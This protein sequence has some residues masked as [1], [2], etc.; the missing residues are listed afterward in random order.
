MNIFVVDEDPQI[1]ARML[2]DKH[3]I[4]MILESAQM[5]STVM[6][7]NNVANPPYRSTHKHHPCTKWAGETMDN[8][9]WLIRHFG[10]MCH[11]YT[12]RY[13]KVHKCQ[14]YFQDF[15][16]AGYHVTPGPLT[17]FAL[18]MPEQYRCPDAVQSYRHYYRAE[19]ARFATWRIRSAPAWFI[20]E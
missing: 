2:C 3:V 11:E 1:A 12:Y 13:N 9:F 16:N 17:P 14:Q 10:T 6:H 20:G 15:V 18:A 4:K 8:Y 5:L 19:K 7:E